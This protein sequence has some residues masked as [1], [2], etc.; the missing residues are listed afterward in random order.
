MQARSIGICCSCQ[1]ALVCALYVPLFDFAG[2]AG[3]DDELFP[4]ELVN[5]SIG[6]DEAVFSAGPTGSW[7][8]ALRERGWIE[9]DESGWHLW[10]TGY[11]GTPSGIRRVGYA[12]SED[13]V[14]WARPFDRPLIEDLWVEDM[15]V[16]RHGSAWYMFAEGWEDR[17]QLLISVDR[18]HWQ[19]I[20]PLDIRKVNGTPIEPGAFGTPTVW[21]EGEIWYLF[22]EHSDQGVWLA[23]SRDLAVW[24]NVADEPVLTIGPGGYD[25]RMIAL[26]Q[27]IKH[28]DR[29][30]A[31]YHGS[32]SPMSPRLWSPSIA[33]SEDLI[34]WTKYTHN[35][36]LLPEANKSSGMLIQFED[37]FR[38]YTMHRQVEIH[39]AAE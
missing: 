6:Q 29:Y 31:Y 9:R 38:L 36:L 25:S 33:T 13:G 8:S 7:D 20:G 23:T 21:I 4:L 35:P 3:G 10:Y 32:G 18:I 12:T 5:F 24:T 26:N 22:Y 11:D 19:R 30:F 16:V 17:A 37:E 39:R 15:T 34:H 27:I 28:E 2:S 14:H 1:L